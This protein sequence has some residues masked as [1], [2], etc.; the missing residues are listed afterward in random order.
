MPPMNLC[1]SF[2][3]DLAHGFDLKWSS[4]SEFEVWHQKEEES[5]TIELIR[6]ELRR[7][8]TL[9]TPKLWNKRHIYICGHGFA[10]G[11]SHYQKKHAWMHKVPLKHTGCPC[12]LTIAFYPGTNIILSL[13]KDQHSH[14]IGNQNARFTCLPKKTQTEIEHLLHLGVELKKVVC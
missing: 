14:E 13:Y 5:E 1:G 7:N 6:K 10:G 12:W 8:N 2:E 4:L 9:D 11:K 3:Y